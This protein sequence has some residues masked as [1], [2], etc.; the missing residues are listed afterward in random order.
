MNQSASFKYHFQMLNNYFIRKTNG[1]S[2][3]EKKFCNSILIGLN[4]YFNNTHDYINSKKYFSKRYDEYT[5]TKV[6]NEKLRLLFSFPNLNQDKILGLLK[7]P[8]VFIEHIK[9]F[10]L[11]NEL[12]I[13]N[14]WLQFYNDAL[15]DYGFLVNYENINFSSAKKYLRDN[16][17]RLEV[18]FS[19]IDI[20]AKQAIAE[21]FT[22][23]NKNE[24]IYNLLLEKILWN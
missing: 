13:S 22:D 5:K 7:Y 15:I 23:I 12:E 11:E 6:E 3:E 19:H 1:T 21:K 9:K 16:L 18:Y 17:P 4:E 2:K 8:I 10:E 20:Y 24:I 14:R